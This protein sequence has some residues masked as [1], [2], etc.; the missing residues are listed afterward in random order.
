M[1]PFVSWKLGGAIIASAGVWWGVA[2]FTPGTPKAIATARN[3]LSKLLD[4]EQM[5]YAFEGDERVSPFDP[6]HE[7]HVAPYLPR[8]PAVVPLVSVVEGCF[9][10]KPSAV[11]IRGEEHVPFKCFLLW[12]GAG[13]RCL[14]IRVKGWSFQQKLDN[15][16]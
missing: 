9:A 13:Y 8:N 16:G 3:T 6:D 12:T 10:V 7:D 11:H 2:T 5:A 4:H 15:L 1:K 14:D